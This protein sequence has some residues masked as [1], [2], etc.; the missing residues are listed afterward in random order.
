MKVKSDLL[1]IRNQIHGLVDSSGDHTILAEIYSILL[2]ASDSEK[3]WYEQLGEA[4]KASIERG[5]AEI[6][7]GN[8]ISQDDLIEESKS[9]AN[10]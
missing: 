10:R 3:D 2:N 1:E 4:D 6:A 9:W 8:G 5:A 7:A